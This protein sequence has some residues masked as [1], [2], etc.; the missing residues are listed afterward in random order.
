MPGYTYLWSNGATTQTI[1]NLGPGTYT[2]TI[3]DSNGCTTT[4]SVTLAEGAEPCNQDTDPGTVSTGQTFC[5]PG[6]T[7]DRLVGTTPTGGQGSLRYLWMFS[8]GSSCLLYTSPSPRDAT[9]SRMPSS[10]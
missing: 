5:G 7:P 2:V 9:L 10:A 1:T 4:A 3:T 6:V 8:T